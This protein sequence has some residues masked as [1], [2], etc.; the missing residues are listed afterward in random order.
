[1]PPSAKIVFVRNFWHV[2]THNKKSYETNDKPPR[3]EAESEDGYG[4]GFGQ[5]K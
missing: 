3:P 1:M 4:T 2:Q 5:T